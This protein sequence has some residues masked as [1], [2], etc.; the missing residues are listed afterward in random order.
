MRQTRLDA[1]RF[2]GVKRKSCKSRS[3]FAEVIVKVI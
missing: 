1:M 3:T 2:A